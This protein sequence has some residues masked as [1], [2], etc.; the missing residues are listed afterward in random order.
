MNYRPP[1]YITFVDFKVDR[2]QY[3]YAPHMFNT[4]KL[5]LDIDLIYILYTLM[6][7]HQSRP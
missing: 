2:L 5:L 6:F 3:I 1:Q 4:M 7:L